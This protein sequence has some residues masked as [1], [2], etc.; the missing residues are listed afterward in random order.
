V[1]AYSLG[2][3]KPLSVVSDNGTEF[4]SMA[5][6]GWS[7]DAQVEWHYIAPGKP[8]QLLNETLLT[9]LAHARVVLDAWKE[10]YNTVRPHSGFGNVPPA[11]YAKRS[12]PHMQGQ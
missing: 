11:V 10:D 4:T 12:A 1:H 8:Q 6:L 5:I 3:G 2:R 7:Q 9:S